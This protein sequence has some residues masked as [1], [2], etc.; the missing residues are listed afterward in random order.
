MGSNGIRFSISDL[1][2]HT[3]RILPTIYQDRVGIS[4]YD[5]QYSSGV[6]E[7]IP[8]STIKDVCKALLHFKATCADFEVPTKHIRVVSTEATR[9]A[10]NSVNFRQTIREK[11]GWEVELMT[12]DQEGRTGAMGIASSYTQ[13]HGLVMDLGGGSIQLSWMMTENGNVQVPWSISLPYGAAALSRRLQAA[14]GS[15][16]EREELKK[17]V[18][19]ALISAF[20]SF[21]HDTL[22]CDDSCTR[23]HRFPLFLS[24]G[25]FRGWGHVLMDAHPITP[26]PIPIING[27]SVKASFF[28]DMPALEAHIASSAV[29]DSGIFRISSRRQSQLPAISFLISQLVKAVPDIEGIKFAQ[30]GVR[31]GLLFSSLKPETRAQHPLS[32]ATAQYAAPSSSALLQLLRSVECTNLSSQSACPQVILDLL[33]SYTNLLYY[34][35]PFPRETRAA[36]SLHCTMTG[37]LASVHGV[38][39]VERATLSLLLC[40]RW[41]GEVAPVS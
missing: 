30:G 9:E 27:F 2:P 23:S 11:V 40:Q 29:K 39:H 15:E 12:K 31:E 5:A 34:F 35:A 41:G 1:S 37:I 21:K 7:P 25:G 6:Q 16:H 32:V 28:H 8:D 19:N 10:I 13:V 18:Y 26:Y 14:S 38:S 33:A 4:L 20:T 3:A 36:V 17:E 24:G 22:Q